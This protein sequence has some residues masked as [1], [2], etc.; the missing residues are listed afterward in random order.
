MGQGTRE[1]K[2]RFENKRHMYFDDKKWL[3]SVTGIAGKAEDK[4]GLLDWYARCVA[5]C[6]IEE[7]AE[8]SRRRRLDGD[9]EAFEW[10]RRAADRKRDG[11]SVSGS[12]LHDVAD[13]M[14]SGM[15]MPEYLDPAVKFMAENVTSFMTEYGVIVVHSEARLCN[16]TL[17]YAGTTDQ[18]GIVPQ[19]GELPLIID[20]KTSA[21]MY[22]RPKFSHGKNGMQLAPYSRAEVIFWDDKTESDMPK[23]NQEVGLIV[24]VRPEGYKVYEYDLV[25]SW[26]QFERALD[27]YHWWRN[28]DEMA[29]GPIRPAGLV[30]N[31]K[32]AAAVAESPEALRGLYERAVH[33]DVWSEELKAVF[34]ARRAELELSEVA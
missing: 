32:A 34:S 10:L 6:A 24:M 25:R 27:N 21:S 13:R 16:R 14:L 30:D 8:L 33:Y 15:D 4:G 23:V 28:V 18:I 20:W 3:P 12:D 22:N 19:Y 7:A 17:A 1:S 26:P 11:A 9:E 2:L 5:E 31:L 29:R